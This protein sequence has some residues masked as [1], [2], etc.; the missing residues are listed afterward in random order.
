MAKRSKKTSLSARDRRILLLAKAGIVTVEIVHGCF[1]ADQHIGAAESALQRLVKKGYLA[2]EPLDTQRVYYRLTSKGARAIGISTSDTWALKKQG[3]I[4]R[5]AVTWFI[6]AQRPGERALVNPH[7]YPERFP[8]GGH[9][10]PRCPFFLDDTEEKLR[11]GIIL[12]DHNAHVRRMSRKTVKLLG[13][14]LHHGWFDGF[15]SQGAFMVTI[16]TF[17]KDRKRAFDRQVPGAIRKRL[18]CALS[19]I[20]P[21]YAVRNPIIVQVHVIPGMDLIVTHGS[22]RKGK[23]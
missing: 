17:L 15:I 12:V 5:Y 4:H 16:L 8:V 1:M 10:L 9:T 18:G 20:C 13:R 11:L 14:F 2:S 6:H 23:Q 3:R 21:D 7:D 22:D 19:R